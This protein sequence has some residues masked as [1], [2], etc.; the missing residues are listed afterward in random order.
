M[1]FRNTFYSFYCFIFLAAIARVP[2]LSTARSVDVYVYIKY[3]SGDAK[4]KKEKTQLS[5]NGE[6]FLPIVI[7]HAQAS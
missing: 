6:G 7:H 1:R 3:V 5:M 2:E 4:E